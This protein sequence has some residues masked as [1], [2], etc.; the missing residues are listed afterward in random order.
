MMATA[1]LVTPLG[2]MT[3][4][5]RRGILLGLE[6]SEAAFPAMDAAFLADKSFLEEQITGQTTP[7]MCMKNN[8][9]DLSDI[10][11]LHRLTRSLA[12][13]FS[14]RPFEYSG[15]FLFSGL[16]SFQEKVLCLTR[17]IS[18]GSTITYG[19]LARR[20]GNPRAAQAV[21]AALSRNPL[22]ILCPCHRVVPADGTVG[23][24]CAGSWRKTALLQLEQ[25]NS[26]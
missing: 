18:H 23:G 16:T 9:V 12:R 7:V 6:F 25:M 19:E 13:Y 4:T 14:G 8:A 21:G 5:V 22:L 17:T 26:R 20:L 2:P 11:A 3:A 15:S 10:H 1:S 24:Y